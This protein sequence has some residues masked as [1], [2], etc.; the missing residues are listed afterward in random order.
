MNGIR[1]NVCKRM[2][3]SR[4]AVSNDEM[5]SFGAFIE[6]RAANNSGGKAA[7]M[8]D[9]ALPMSTNSSCQI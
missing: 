4:K 6:A 2:G 8:D 1:Q 9:L 5:I 7:A 3:L